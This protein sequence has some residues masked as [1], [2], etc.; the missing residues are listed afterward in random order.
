MDSTTPTAPALLV[1]QDEAARLLGVGRTTIWRMVKRHD[2]DQ[3]N[4][5]R[6]ALV[7][8][9]SIDAYVSGESSAK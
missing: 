6:R 7:T 1:D 3:V 5:G 8:R 2:L 9:A 4:I